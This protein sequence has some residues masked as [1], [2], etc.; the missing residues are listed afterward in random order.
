MAKKNQEEHLHI[1][2]DKDFK[3]YLEDRADEVGLTVSAFVKSTLVKS[4]QYKKS[5]AEDREDIADA[6]AAL[7]EPG[8]DISLEELKEEL[9]L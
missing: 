5:T 6:R 4:T 8:E 1:R 2:I 9:S 3:Q 7:S